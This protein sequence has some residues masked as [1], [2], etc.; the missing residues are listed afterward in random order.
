VKNE[1]GQD[2]SIRCTFSTFLQHSKRGD[3]ENGAV[4]TD[5]YDNRPVPQESMLPNETEGGVSQDK[6]EGVKSK[7]H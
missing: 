6:S 7:E 1:L 5:N 3:L 4:E 2:I